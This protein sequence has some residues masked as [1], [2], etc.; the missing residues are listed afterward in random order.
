MSSPVVVVAG[1][2]MRRWEAASERLL[3]LGGA[4]TSFDN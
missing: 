3:S 1:A 2:V 4:D